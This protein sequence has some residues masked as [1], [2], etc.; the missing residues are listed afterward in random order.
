MTEAKRTD[1][2]EDFKS[3]INFCQYASS[4]G[5]TLDPKQSS[6]SSAVMRHANG[7]KLIVARSPNRHWIYFNVHDARDRGTIIDFVQIRD[8]LSLGEV[9]KE[10]RPWIGRQEMIALAKQPT[11]SELMP[12]EHD[13]ARVLDV[14]LKAQA[15]NGSQAYLEQQR[16]IPQAVMGNPIFADR[17]RIDHRGNALFPHFSCDGLCGFEIKNNNGFTGY[18]PGG[19]KG[20]WCSRPQLDDLQLVICETAIDALSYAALFGVTRTRFVSTA[21]QISPAQAKLLQSAAEKFPEEGQIVLAM[22]NDPGGRQLVDTISQ[23]LSEIDLANKLLVV[24]QPDVEGEDWNDVL[25]R[26]GRTSPASPAFG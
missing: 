19:V 12:V 26:T 13:V 6:R 22:D 11:F 24:R 2:L 9:R 25:K 1:E 20:L 7:D 23:E 18:S 16:K 4:R 10:L 5:F 3:Q 17:I 21:G 15:V 8:R 14:W